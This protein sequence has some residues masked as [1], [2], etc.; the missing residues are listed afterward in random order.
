MMNTEIETEY[1]LSVLE[2]LEGDPEYCHMRLATWM[3]CS[4]SQD[5]FAPF[6]HPGRVACDKCGDCEEPDGNDG[7]D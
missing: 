5:N 3:I 7:G 6:T 4:D 2:L 1:R